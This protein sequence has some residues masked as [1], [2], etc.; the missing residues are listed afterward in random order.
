[1]E[2]VIVFI[3]AKDETEAALI[4]HSLVEERLAACVNIIKSVRSIYRWEG[5][6][7][8]ENETLLI[9]KTRRGLFDKL[10]KKVKTLHSYAVPEIIA[11]QIAEG[12]AEYLSWLMQ[13][14]EPP[15]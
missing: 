14:I 10:R 11:A 6:V 9:A 1:M 7:E 15:A 12:S 13:E 8:D 4:A 3:T 2:P 5:K